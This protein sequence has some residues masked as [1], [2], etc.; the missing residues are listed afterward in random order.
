MSTPFKTGYL[1]DT[2]FLVFSSR[3]VR[4][5]GSRG[6]L[7]RDRYTEGRELTPSL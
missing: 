5:L 7:G 1:N 2:N 4:Q 6:T 3:V